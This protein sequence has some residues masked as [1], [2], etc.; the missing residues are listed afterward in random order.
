MV[1]LDGENTT[2]PLTIIDGIISKITRGFLWGGL[3]D[4]GKLE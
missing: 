2:L 4:Y 3:L 1:H